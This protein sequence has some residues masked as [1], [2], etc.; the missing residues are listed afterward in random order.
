[1]AADANLRGAIVRGL[2]RHYPGFD[3]V[4]V[5]DV[6]VVNG[7][8][9]E[10]LLAWAGEQ[11][12]MLVSHNVSTLVSAMTRV[13]RRA[14]SVARVLLIPANVRNGQVID[15][16]LLLDTASHPDDWAAGLLYLPL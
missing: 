5:Q 4:R 1:M 2:V 7:A 15:D 8:Q 10:V 13:R 3:I 9:D 14:Q 11:G 6:P 12:R 16:M